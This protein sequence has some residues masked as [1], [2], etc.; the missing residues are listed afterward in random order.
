M[1]RRSLLVPL[2][3]SFWLC[4]WAA[5]LNA[6]TIEAK[7]LSVDVEQR[8]YSVEVLKAA[9]TDFSKGDRVDFRVGRGDAELDYVGQTVRGAANYYSKRWNLETIFPLTGDG[10]QGMRDVNRRLRSSTATMSRRKFVR[11]GDYVPD[12]GMINQAGEF[13]QVRALRGK[14]FVLNFIFTRC[15][16]PTMCPASSSRMVELQAQA[17]AAGLDELH[18]VTISFDPEFDSPG[19]LK[20]YA[21]GYGIDLTNFQLWTNS[22]P[23]VIED[24]LRQFGIMTIEEDGTI[25][26]TMATLLV[27][28]NGRVAY[29][30]EGSQWTVKEFLQAAQ[31]LY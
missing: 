6:A 22:D 31:K 18:F 21:E 29:R 7:V 12:F 3:L 9:D 8:L 2:L 16:A 24:L 23:Q 19:V 20:L 1:F 28:P 13:V 14:S 26:H 25:N 15:Q 27:D 10:A 5:H 4:A 17:Q 30:K 11:Q